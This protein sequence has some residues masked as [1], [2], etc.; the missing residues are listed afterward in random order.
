MTDQSRPRRPHG[1][2]AYFLALGASMVLGGLAGAGS[3]FFGDQPGPVGT[4]VT[5]ALVTAAMAVGFTACLWWWRGIDE[6]ARE[7][8]KWAWWWGGSGGMA[9]GSVL[10]LT[11][12]L[13]AEEQPISAKFGSTPADIFVSGMMCIMLFQLAGYALA[14]A[15]WWLKHR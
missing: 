3:A 2:G 7:A 8:H 13:R 11:L 14:W 4:A 9:V 15:G 5:A 6:A 1:P 12:M 10:L